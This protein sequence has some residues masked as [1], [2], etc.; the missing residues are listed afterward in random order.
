VHLDP[1]ERMTTPM[2]KWKNFPNW[3]V[4]LAELHEN[5]MKNRLRGENKTYTN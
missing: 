2:K 3:I 4:G 5:S 1:S